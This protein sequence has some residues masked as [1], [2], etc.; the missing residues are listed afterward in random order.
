MDAVY[1]DRL[2]GEKYML[3]LNLEGYK[4]VPIVRNRA[5]ACATLICRVCLNP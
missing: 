4:I 2:E 3:T 5:F 1:R